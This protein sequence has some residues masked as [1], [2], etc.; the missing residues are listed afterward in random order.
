VLLELRFIIFL[1]T[2]NRIVSIQSIRLYTR[3]SVKRKK[4]E[5]KAP[6]GRTIRTVRRTKETLRTNQ[7]LYIKCTY[8]G[9]LHLRIEIGRSPERP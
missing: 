2:K 1:L 7:R 8:P 4:E 9:A 6:D 3:V 5:D